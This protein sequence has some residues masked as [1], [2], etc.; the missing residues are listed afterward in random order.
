M[1]KT[2]LPLESRVA[3]QADFE[4]LIT[5]EDLTESG[6][7]TAQTLTFPIEAKMSA[8]CVRLILDE[9]FE[10]TA[11]AGNNTT[12]VEVGDGGDTDRFLTSTELNKNGTEINLKAGTGTVY[13]YT[14]TDTVDILVTPKTGTTLAS[15]NKGRMRLQFR[16]NDERAVAPA[17]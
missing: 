9:A 3:Q 2:P 17:P 12:L 15:L 5:H 6:S 13:P 10:D 16:I 14:A 1:L 7:G 11:T 8:E 4:V